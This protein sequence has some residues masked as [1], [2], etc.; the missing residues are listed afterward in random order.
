MEAVDSWLL[1]DWNGTDCGDVFV[2][3]RCRMSVS[4]GLCLDDEESW[5]AVWIDFRV[6][7]CG[8]LRIFFCEG[9][10]WSNLL[11]QHLRCE[12]SGQFMLDHY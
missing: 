1:E 12:M 8:P 7:R 4:E 3:S 2:G 9:R 11:S 6:D 5:L 10:L